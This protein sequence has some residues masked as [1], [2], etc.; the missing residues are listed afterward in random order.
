MKLIK[1][2]HSCFAIEKDGQSLIV[3]PG[4]LSQDFVVPDA[5]VTCVII[6]HIHGDHL[7]QDKL[8]AIQTRHPDVAIYAHEQ[9]IGELDSDIKN[10][11]VVSSG[12]VVTV[13]NFKLEFG[14]GEH[15]LIHPSIPMCANLCVRIDDTVYYPGDSLD[16]PDR[17]TKILALP[18]AAPW[19]KTS[20]AM[21]YLVDVKPELAFPMHDGVL[22]DHGKMFVDAWIQRAA[23]EAGC[24]YRRL[25]STPFVIE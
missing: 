11:H 18:I 12:D 23:D 22:S 20:E 4:Q 9:V 10:T 15:A 3:D 16:K 14:G 5:Q 1:F 6:T 17:P 24:E 21:D 7:D 13:G 25:D 2:Q 19:L 8:R